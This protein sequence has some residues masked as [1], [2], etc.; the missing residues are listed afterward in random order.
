MKG[1]LQPAVVVTSVV[2]S[3]L[4]RRFAGLHPEHRAA[5]S[6]AHR[7]FAQHAQVILQVQ[8]AV[9]QTLQQQDFSEPLTIQRDVQTALLRIQMKQDRLNS[10]LLVDVVQALV[11]LDRAVAVQA[12]SPPA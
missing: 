8:R 3:I 5:L 6:N 11:D 12:Q 2:T 7:F 4:L 1:D 10:Q 9:M